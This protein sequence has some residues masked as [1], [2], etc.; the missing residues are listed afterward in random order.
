MKVQVK[1]CGVQDLKSAEAAVA[2]GADFLGFNFV[3][4]SKRYIDPKDAKK[5]IKEIRGKTNVVGVFQNA[6]SD[7]V[8]EVS[9]LLDLDF[10]QLHGEE[11]EDYM[12][13]I[14]KRII[15]KY[16]LYSF[17]ELNENSKYVLLD[18]EVQG[19]GKMLDLKKAAKI[20]NVF[21]IFFSGGLTP[22][23]VADVVKKVKPF[24]VDVAGG[25]E[26]NGK[27]DRKKIKQ[28][29]HNAKGATI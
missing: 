18:R 28:F 7:A 5:I 10:V 27:Q 17:T 15:K 12:K 25:V 29:V 13:K 2:A 9:E 19:E 8:N 22:E 4:T 23:N 16:N 1:I 11:D 6:S 3:P 26:T 24:A 21:S 14:K 20:S